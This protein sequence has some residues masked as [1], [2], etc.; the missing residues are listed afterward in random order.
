MRNITFGGS[1]RY[2]IKFVEKVVFTKHL[3]IMIKSGISLTEAI[4]TLA[5]QTKGTTLGDIT[6]RLEK[7]IE[8][9]MAL[10]KSLKRFPKVF[11]DFYVSMV[12][13]GEVAGTLEENLDFL[14]K[15][16]AKEDALNKKIKGAMLYPVIVLTAAS[17]MAMFISL[18][19]L[20]QFVDF[21][22]AFDI[23]L[24]FTTRVLLGVANFMKEDG[25]LFFSTLFIAVVFANFAVNLKLIKPIW[26]R[27]MLRLPLFGKLIIYGSLANF[28]RNFSV[29]LESGI[30]VTQSL[31]ITS[32]TLSNLV[33]K[34]EVSKMNM[35]LKKGKSLSD[36]IEKEMGREFPILV[37][38]MIGVG[39]KTGNLEETLSYLADFYEDEIDGITKR[40]T[41]VLEPIMLLV[42][43][44][45]VGFVALAIITPIYEL[46]GSIQG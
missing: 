24:P 41:T 37:S 14:A 28:S 36:V 39:E 1:K 43:G 30:T 19:I 11:D 15:H 18:Y 20:P 17:L 4:N 9:G 10:A 40:I 38:R 32:Q 21:F 5:I 6:A 8:N 25:I 3:A 34:K 13:V 44:L 35:F 23:E 29:L 33:Y 2:K 16:L 27:F 22:E 46:T 26:H 45:V 12:E 31:E 42:I 7:D